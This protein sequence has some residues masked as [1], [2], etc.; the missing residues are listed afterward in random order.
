M[1]TKKNLM[2]IATLASIASVT[3]AVVGSLYIQQVNAQNQSNNSPNPNIS[4]NVAGCLH[5]AGS[6]AQ[7]IHSRGTLTQLASSNNFLEV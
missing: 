4:Q 2:I 1:V 7:G 3:T 5:G 6:S